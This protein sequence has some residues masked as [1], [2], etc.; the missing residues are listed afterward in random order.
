MSTGS[1]PSSPSEAKIL[2]KRKTRSLVLVLILV[3][4]FAAISWYFKNRND[5]AN[6]GT[7]DTVGM[8]AAV[9][10][11]DDGQRVVAFDAK[12]TKIEPGGSNKPGIVERDPAWQPDGQRLFYVSNRSGTRGSQIFRW[13]PTANSEPSERSLGSLG[14]T[15]PT[16]SAE[17]VPD[18]NAYLLMVS[19]G[20]V[21]E[22]D[23]KDN[24]SRQ[25]LPPVAG[26][27]P[28]SSADT[29]EGGGQE[30]QFSALYHDLGESFRTA[31]WCAQK[32][33]VVAVMRRDH[34]EVLIVQQLP[35]PGEKP[36]RPMVLVNAEH[37]DFD[38]SPK[39][40]TI[41]FSAENII[42]PPDQEKA[43]ADA[44]KK[45]PHARVRHTLGFFKVGDHVHIIAQSPDDQLAFGA[46]A[47]SPVGDRVLTV[48]GAYDHD[49]TSVTSKELVAFPLSE[50]SGAAGSVIV[51]GQ[52][53]DPSWGPGASQIAYIKKTESGKRAIFVINADG[54][55]DHN[56]SGDKNDYAQPRFSPQTKQP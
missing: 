4:A 19:G 14:K 49:S 18:Q 31:E 41:A 7:A 50:G 24:K 23:P 45:N 26:E 37:I 29:E 25:L 17:Q 48:V 3:I 5:I 39:D 16:F 38:V 53:T 30:G 51:R 6:F 22:F 55:N 13:T 54:T 52:A 32:Q 10:Y 2:S 47:I 11:L 9:E 44:L 15:D 27:V 36:Q 12:G 40:G 21:L 35:K 1:S 34:G 33:A 43:A 28:T 56:I 8:V 42:L 46:V 20:F